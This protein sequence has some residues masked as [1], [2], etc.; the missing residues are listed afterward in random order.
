MPTGDDPQATLGDAVLRWWVV[1]AALIAAAYRAWQRWVVAPREAQART[2][3][4]IE[5]LRED[6]AVI[7]DELAQLRHGTVSA[8]EFRELRRTIND[9]LVTLAT[10]KEQ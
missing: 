1:F 3:T 5:Q 7:G 6:I 10:A 4:A 9:H 8:D 2:I